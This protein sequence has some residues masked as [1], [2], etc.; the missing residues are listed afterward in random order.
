MLGIKQVTELSSFETKGY[1]IMEA[2]N[3]ALCLSQGDINEFSK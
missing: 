1:G 3:S 2:H